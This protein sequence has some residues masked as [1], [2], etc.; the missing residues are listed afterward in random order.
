MNARVPLPFPGVSIA[1]QPGNDGN[2]P[3]VDK[4]YIPSG[5]QRTTSI[6]GKA[7]LPMPGLVPSGNA[8]AP[9]GQSTNYVSDP[10]H[11][12]TIVS[13]SNTPG[14]VAN[15]DQI[16]FLLAPTTQRNLLMLRNASLGGQNILVEFGKPCSTVT[17]LLLVPNQIILFDEVV[18]QDDL[19]CACDIA[20]GILAFAYSTIPNP[21]IP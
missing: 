6:G 13:A 1:P 4:S 18:S 9:V 21:L 10:W 17:V 20:G 8:A 11:Q 12:A 14:V 7:L 19:Y 16:P 5:P 2:S 15:A 3:W